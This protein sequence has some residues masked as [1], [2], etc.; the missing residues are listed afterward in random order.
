MPPDWLDASGRARIEGARYSL[1]W[2]IDM[3]AAWEALL[4]RLGGAADPDFVDWLA[5]D[6]SDAREF[7]VG[8]HRRFL[9][10]MK[11]FAQVVLEPAHGVMMTSATLKD[12]KRLGQRHRAL[13][14]GMA[15]CR[16]A[17]HRAGKP[18]RLCQPTPKS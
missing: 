13:R 10:P 12:G 8:L 7:D 3:L 11:P 9:D 5:V 1:G 14:R 17:Y 18:V 6:R 2:R 4:G 15:R 16:A